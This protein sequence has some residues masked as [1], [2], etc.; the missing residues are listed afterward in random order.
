ME[1]LRLVASHNFL[2]PLRGEAGIVGFHMFDEVSSLFEVLD[3]ESYWSYKSTIE[4]HLA[5]QGV[6]TI[7]GMPRYTRVPGSK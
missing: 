5:I 3:N 1:H 7:Q 2:F 6:L 4:E